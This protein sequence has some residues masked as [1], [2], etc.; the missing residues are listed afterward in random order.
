MRDR[1]MFTSGFAIFAVVCL[2][3]GARV[4]NVV[5]QQEQDINS[6]EAELKR[7]LREIRDAISK[8][9]RVCASG[10]VGPMDR[11]KD[12]ECYPPTLEV[13]VKGIS[14]P[15]DNVKLVF[16]E[17]IPKDPM[18]GEIDWGLRSAQDPPDSTSW[19]GQNVANIY[20][21]SEDYALDGTRY[22][23]W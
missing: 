9:K 18:T 17:R 16:L 21:K 4:A 15:W 6:R 14:R 20:S 11:R 2:I 10:E 19:G 5:A 1:R 12:D 3:W 23:D 13:L 8:Y 7:S 22:K